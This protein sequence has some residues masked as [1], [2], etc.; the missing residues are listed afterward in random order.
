MSINNYSV[1]VKGEFKAFIEKVDKN[2]EPF[3]LMKETAIRYLEGEVEKIKKKINVLK[4]LDEM[5][6]DYLV[7]IEHQDK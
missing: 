6:A 3:H 7:L 5:P 4:N 2:G 1:K